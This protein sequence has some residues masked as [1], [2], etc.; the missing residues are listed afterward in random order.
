MNGVVLH[1]QW[2]IRMKICI[3]ISFDDLLTS[4]KTDADENNEFECVDTELSVDS[5]NVA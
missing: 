5:N 1:I 3:K 2:Q 4:N